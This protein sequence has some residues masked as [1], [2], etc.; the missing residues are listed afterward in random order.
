M[1]TNTASLISHSYFL[2]DQLSGSNQPVIHL[3]TEVIPWSEKNNIC[4]IK[5]GLMVR[6]VE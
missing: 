2:L 6:S 1:D 3:T 4:A 5:Y